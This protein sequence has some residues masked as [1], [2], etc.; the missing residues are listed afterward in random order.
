MRYGFDAARPRQTGAGWGRDWLSQEACSV[1]W[2]VCMGN[3]PTSQPPGLS[4]N[5]LVTADGWSPGPSLCCKSRDH[6]CAPTEAVHPVLASLYNITVPFEVT[7]PRA[8][9]CRLLPLSC[10]LLA[11]TSTSSRFRIR[12]RILAH[13]RNNGIVAGQV[14]LR[15]GPLYG[16]RCFGPGSEVSPQL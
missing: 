6:V 15:L 8:P 2:R 10:C 11:T 14:A 16:S 5:H 4:L 3:P 13:V 9:L 12:I 1:A 7:R